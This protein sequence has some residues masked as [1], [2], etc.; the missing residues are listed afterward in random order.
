MHG[1]QILYPVAA[2]VLLVIVV[3]GMMLRERITEMKARRIHPQKAPSSTQLNALLLNTKGSDNF[4]NLFE[5]P[6]LFYVL[7]LAL[8]ITANVSTL[9]L[10]LAWAYVALRCVHSYIHL[11]Y[12]KVM[13]RF[14]VFLA[15]GV[16]LAVMWLLFLAS[17][18]LR[19]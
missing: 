5:L 16:V 4:R 14:F 15:S 11:G 13:H 12:N 1:N 2:M 18:L 8:L 3:A 9:Q 6:M 19:A 17:L 7:C 10:A